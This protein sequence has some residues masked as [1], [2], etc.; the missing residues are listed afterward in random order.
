VFHEVDDSSVDWRDQARDILHFLLYY[1]PS[2]VSSA[3]LPIHLPRL[4][5]DVARTRTTHGWT[6][7]NLIGIGHS[8]GAIGTLFAA[9]THPTL[10][11]SIV[12]VE[13]VLGPPVDPVE[14]VKRLSRVVAPVAGRRSV[15][16]SL[17]D[18]RADLA[19]FPV[20]R[21]FHQKEVD[22]YLENALYVR[23]DGKI[24]LKQDPVQEALVFEIRSPAYAWEL[25][26]HLDPRM[27]VHW[28]RGSRPNVFSGKGEV[29]DDVIR[30]LSAQ[31]NGWG[32]SQSW[33]NGAHLAVQDDP[34]GVGESSLLRQWSCLT[35]V[36]ANSILTFLGNK[37]T[38]E[39]K[40]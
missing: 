24:A 16:S 10:F 26:P 14:T 3:T 31:R 5:D 38:L 1:I 37:G 25:A 4:S 11:N 39:A 6:E 13:A 9:L 40:L 36:L 17:E 33:I 12:L 29:T 30:R 23:P 35:D 27:D 20:F 21:G 2:A 34:V 19:V 15:W 28:I 8:F 7:R 32:V 22:V 18:A